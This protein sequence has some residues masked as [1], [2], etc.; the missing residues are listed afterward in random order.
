MKQDDKLAFVDATE[1]EISDH[2]KGGHWSIVHR[3]TLPNKA[4][5]I[6]EIWYF[7]RKRKP[8]G[9]LLKHKARLCAH[10]GMQQ[11]GDS[12]WETYSPV[13][14]IL[15]VRLILAISKLHNLNSKSID[16][17]LAFPQ[18]DLEEDIWMYLPIGFKVDGHT[19]VSYERSFLLKL[20]KKVYGLKQGSYNWYEK[21][22][23][24]L[25]DRG[26]KPSEIDPCLYIGNGMIILTYADDC[27]IVGPS[28]GNINRFVNSMK[29]GDE[30]FVLIDEGD[31]NKL[32]GI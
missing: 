12:Y 23:K 11:W 28:M 32:L 10:G 29:N 13:V 30:N 20:N 4:R 8:D 1:K 6:K 5:P 2:E 3:D 26:F 22:K 27:I 15:S 25:V 31:I 16:F 17:V 19:E 7:K 24:S 18:A 21:L 14:N 9:E